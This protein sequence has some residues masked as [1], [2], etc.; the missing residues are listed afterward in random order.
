MRLPGLDRLPDS[1]RIWIFGAEQEVRGEDAAALLATV[2]RFLDGWTAHGTPLPAARDWCCHRF[3]IVGVDQDAA[4]PSGCSVDAL[5]RA[6]Q[7]AAAGGTPG[8]P[9]FLGNEAVWYRDGD[10]AVQ[11]AS[12]PEFRRLARGGGA[13]PDTVVFDNS[14]TELGQLRAGRWEGPASERW[15]AVFFEQSP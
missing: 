15:Q 6:L 10:G 5:V 7:D 14:I 8:A 4:P 3:L 12:R 2:D 13:T 9:R 11:W 1:A